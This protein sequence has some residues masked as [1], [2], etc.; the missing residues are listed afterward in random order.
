MSLIIVLY[1]PINEAYIYISDA[2]KKLVEEVFHNAIDSLSDDDKKL[3][4]VLKY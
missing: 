4:H 1:K 2:E 3:P